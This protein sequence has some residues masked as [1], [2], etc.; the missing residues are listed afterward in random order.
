LQTP[1]LLHTQSVD[2]ALK[3]IS[4]ILIAYATTSEAIS[5]RISKIAMCG[6]IYRHEATSSRTPMI[7]MCAS[8]IYRH[9]AKSSI[10]PTM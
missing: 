9:E 1:L 3:K 10:T 5:S 4:R 8:N 7:A 6:N 2:P